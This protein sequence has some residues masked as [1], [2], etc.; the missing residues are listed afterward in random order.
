MDTAGDAL[1]NV[2]NATEQTAGSM[3]DGLTTLDAHWNGG[4]AQTCV[5]YTARLSEAL[6]DSARAMVET[7]ESVIEQAKAFLETVQNMAD[8]SEFADA[9]TDAYAIGDDSERAGA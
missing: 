1:I 8:T 6:F 5:D 9:P 4:A 7:I 2:G 3:T